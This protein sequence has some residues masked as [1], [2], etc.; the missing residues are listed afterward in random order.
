M[1]MTRSVS[2]YAPSRLCSPMLSVGFCR[3]AAESPRAV[4]LDAHASTLPRDIAGALADADAL[5]VADV[6]HWLSQA[7]LLESLPLGAFG[8]GPVGLVLLRRLLVASRLSA[9]VL[10]AAAARLPL[11]E[12]KKRLVWHAAVD[13]AYWSG[14]RRRLGCSESWSRLVRGPLILMYHAFEDGRHGRGKYIV[15]ARRFSR[16]LAWLA[17]RR[18]NVITMTELLAYRRRH[19]L[20]PARTLVI[21]IDDGYADNS[22]I[23]YPLLIRH[24]MRALVFVVTHRLGDRNDWSLDCE[25]RGRRLLTW[26]AVR[27]FRPDVIEIGAHTQTHAQLPLLPRR[28][29]ASEVRGSRDDIERELGKLP[30]VFAYPF[31]DVDEQ[32]RGVVQAAGFTAACG[33]RGGFNSPATDLLDLRRVEIRG[34]DSILHFALSTWLGVRV[35]VLPRLKRAAAR[36]RK[37]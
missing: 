26:D 11:G 30:P 16:Q 1:D 17:W 33:L 10:A 12:R 9:R 37:R 13:L 31:G 2:R 15:S 24:R 19:E 36:R 20:A 35:D 14:S 18:Y 5:G 23:A 29:V 32:S 21:T 7:D 6:E 22:E 4:S 25:L 3:A 8:E 34:A 27:N 28:D